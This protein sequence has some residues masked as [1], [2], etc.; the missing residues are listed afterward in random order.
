MRAIQECLWNP[1]MDCGKQ[2]AIEPSKNIIFKLYAPHRSVIVFSLMKSWLVML[3]FLPWLMPVTL[4]FSWTNHWTWKTQKFCQTLIAQLR[5]IADVRKY[6][7][8]NAAKKRLDYC[9][10]LLYGLPSSS[11]KKHI[12][13]EIAQKNTLSHTSKLTCSRRLS[14]N[15]PISVKCLSED[16]L[17][18]GLAQAKIIKKSVILFRVLNMTIWCKHVHRLELQIFIIFVLRTSTS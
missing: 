1:T 16:I 3:E 9:N 7:T 4:V 12:A 17:L 14:V 5:N 15:L 18:K 8:Q 10:S 2:T 6:L 13:K 11:L